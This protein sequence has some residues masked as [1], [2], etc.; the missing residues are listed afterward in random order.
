MILHNTVKQ[1][2]FHNIIIYQLIKLQSK[3]IKKEETN[4]N[5][6]ERNYINEKNGCVS[7]HFERQCN[8]QK[9]TELHFSVTIICSKAS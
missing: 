1:R 7:N 3:K 8:K 9:M 4:K 5:E 6:W 2:E